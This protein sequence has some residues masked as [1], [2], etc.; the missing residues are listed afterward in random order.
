MAPALQIKQN[1]GFCSA[2]SRPNP[3]LAVP[4]TALGPSQAETPHPMNPW[5]KRRSC[6]ASTRQWFSCTGRGFLGQLCPFRISS[7]PLYHIQRLKVEPPE[8]PVGKGRRQ[9]GTGGGGRAGDIPGQLSRRTQSFPPLEVAKVEYSLLILTHPQAR[10]GFLLPLLDF[11][12]VV[13]LFVCFFSFRERVHSRREAG[14]AGED[15][16]GVLGCPS[17]PMGTGRN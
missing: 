14:N 17:P 4:D 2:T 11:K 15:E 6:S 5:C 16:D 12:E 3:G 8:L 13:C 7:G 10:A 1:Q 9:R